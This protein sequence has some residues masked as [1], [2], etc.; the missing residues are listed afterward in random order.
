MPY[1]TRR[2]FEPQSQGHGHAPFVSAAHLSAAWNRLG[3]RDLPANEDDSQL[4]VS[5]DVAEGRS[6]II[7]TSSGLVG[8]GIRT[9]NKR[10]TPLIPV[11]TIL[12]KD[13]ARNEV[14]FP[15]R[16]CSGDRSG[17]NA[18]RR[19]PAGQI[20]EGPCQFQERDRRAP[21][22]DRSFRGPRPFWPITAPA[23]S[24]ILRRRPTSELR[25]N[26]E[27]GPKL[28]SLQTCDGPCVK[29]R[30]AFHRR[31]P[32]PLHFSSPSPSSSALRFTGKPPFCS[33]IPD[34][35]GGI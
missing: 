16:T 19:I 31:D 2:A 35:K 25:C 11:R 34:V 18:G 23:D 15:S 6:G 1:E 21:K 27:E 32:F 13:W 8:K 26:T 20:H 29:R 22:Q 14:E 4:P 12:L 3:N 24:L 5:S 17:R 33:W 9:S 30:E 7:P 28:L 10:K